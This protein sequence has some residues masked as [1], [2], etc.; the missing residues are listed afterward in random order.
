[1][2]S[3]RSRKLVWCREMMSNRHRLPMRWFIST[4]RDK[5]QYFCWKIRI[6]PSQSYVWLVFVQ[7]LP[8]TRRKK[9]FSLWIITIVAIRKRQ[10]SCFFLLLLLSFFTAFK[11]VKKC[12]LYIFV[13]SC[14]T[15][16]SKFF[17]KL[18]C[19]MLFVPNMIHI[20]VVFSFLWPRSM[21]FDSISLFMFHFIQ[22][23]KKEK[24]FATK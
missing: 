4:N 17:A 10:I 18:H 19:L 21:A 1:M 6:F 15:K 7:N 16:R 3:F 20:G 12:N 11:V 14:F 23:A 5:Q 22:F 2:H 24:F 13:L 8:E 9:S